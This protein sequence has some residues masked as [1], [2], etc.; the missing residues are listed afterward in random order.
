MYCIGLYI[1]LIEPIF[2]VKLVFALCGN[3]QALGVFKINS[4]QVSLGPVGEN[5]R[6]LM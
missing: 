6:C 5:E 3:I 2:C 4:I 1:L